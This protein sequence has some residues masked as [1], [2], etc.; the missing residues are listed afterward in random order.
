MNKFIKLTD[1]CNSREIYFNLSHIIK[2][3]INPYD[4]V[5][6]YT[7]DCGYVVVKESIEEVMNLINN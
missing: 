1:S 3:K 7:N 6:I 5:L 4:E 2:I